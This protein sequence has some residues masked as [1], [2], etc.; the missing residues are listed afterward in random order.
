MLNIIDEL[1]IHI[2]KF[3][4]IKLS[5]IIH[6]NMSGKSMLPQIFITQITYFFLFNVNKKFIYNII[7]N[8]NFKLFNLLEI[9]K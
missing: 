7:I 3:L 6:I 2:I 9:N 1:S 5:N 4:I 8:V